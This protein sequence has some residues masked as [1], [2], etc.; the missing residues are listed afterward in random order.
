M[1][2]TPGQPMSSAS[3]ASTRT[4]MPAADSRSITSWALRTASGRPV[5]ATTST[6]LVLMLSPHSQ[7]HRDVPTC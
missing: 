4:V 1:T 5:C 2:T 6:D 7:P 3:S